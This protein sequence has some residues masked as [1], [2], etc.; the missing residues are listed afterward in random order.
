[1]PQL[2]TFPSVPKADTPKSSAHLIA[3]ADNEVSTTRASSKI[4]SIERLEP[5][6]LRK[7]CL[8]IKSSLARRSQIRSNSLHTRGQRGPV[9]SKMANGMRH[10]V[11]NS[12]PSSR[13]RQMCRTNDSETIGVG[14]QREE[15]L[16]MRYD[17]LTALN[18]NNIPT[19]FRLFAKFG[20]MH[21]M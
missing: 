4:F 10:F 12:E 5:T 19:V 2:T 20:Y 15:L 11:R 9:V 21:G 13:R 6:A 18:T 7:K 17:D 8:G 1:M 16:G 3:V 14:Y